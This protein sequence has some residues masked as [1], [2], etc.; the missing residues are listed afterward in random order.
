[1]SR[2]KIIISI[3]IVLIAA[4]AIYSYQEYY[5][6]NKDL[7]Y[8]KAAVTVDAVA[9]INEFVASES[10]A[11]ARYRNKIIAVRGMV[12]SVDTTGDQYSIAMGDTN[13]LSSVR[14]SM[15]SSFVQQ[16]AAVKR[17]MTITVKGAITGFKKDDTGLLG[18]DVEFNRCVME[19]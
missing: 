12:K 19:P 8:V 9:L 17:G 4:A 2:R 14:F 7:R 3:V 5:R 16:A 13:Q 18:D 1:M 10:A 11:D 6:S 15:D